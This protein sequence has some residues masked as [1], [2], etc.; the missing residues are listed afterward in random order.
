MAIFK[1]LMRN[2]DELTS[3]TCCTRRLRKPLYFSRPQNVLLALHQT[4]YE[5]EYLILVPI[6]HFSSEIFNEFYVLNAIFLAILCNF[7]GVIPFHQDL[8][9]HL[10]RVLFEKFYL[11]DTFFH[12]P[13]QDRVNDLHRIELM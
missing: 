11:M 13:C 12:Y 10:M 6:S 7:S 3:L 5:R 2:R 1:C 9:M 8:S 4:F